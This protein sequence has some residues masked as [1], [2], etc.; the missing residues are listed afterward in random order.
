[1]KANAKVSK[2]Q[3]LA[4]RNARISNLIAT[5]MD[6]EAQLVPK[7][8]KL[9]MARWKTGEATHFLQTINDYIG[10]LRNVINNAKL[11]NKGLMKLGPLSKSRVINIL[12]DYFAKMEKILEEMK[13]LMAGLDPLSDTATNAI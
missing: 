10:N 9:A 5:R 3:D 11:F 1:M 7:E 2:P 8:V 4:N 12:V 6:L 13:T